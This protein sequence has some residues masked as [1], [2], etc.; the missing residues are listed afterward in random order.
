MVY[1]PGMDSRDLTTVLDLLY[2]G[3]A[4]VSTCRVEQ[5]ARCMEE[6]KMPGLAVQEE[7]APEVK[8]FDWLNSKEASDGETVKE[9]KS[10]NK[11]KP[12][13]QNKLLSRKSS[14]VVSLTPSLQL[15][16]EEPRQTFSLGPEDMNALKQLWGKLVASTKEEGRKR[17][18]QCKECGKEWVNCWSAYHHVDYHH[19][20]HV[21][22][23]CNN[24]QKVF[25]NHTALK[26][27]VKTKHV[28]KDSIE[29][30]SNRTALNFHVK[31]KHIVKVKDS[32]EDEEL[33]SEPAAGRLRCEAGRKQDMASHYRKVHTDLDRETCKVCGD[34]FKM[35]KKHLMRTK[36]GT[37]KKAEATIPCPEG[38]S[39]MFTLQSSVYK[40]MRHV[41]QKIKNKICPFCEYKTYSLFNL[42]LHV[43]TVHEGKKIEKQQCQYCDKAPYALDYHM[44]TYHKCKL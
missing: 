2:L 42:N 41:H 33:P 22:H 8:H 38:C 9:E 10:D 15:K 24:C 6:L 36:C 12:K 34:R 35:L 39:K 16:E 31:T 28:V 37:G 23:K 1:L 13:H 40:H 44:Q 30:E 32:I 4:T 17:V 5:V 25:S 26:L 11:K 29:D 3:M 27:H 20:P 18:F 43:T 21:Q 14:L 7:S 19:H